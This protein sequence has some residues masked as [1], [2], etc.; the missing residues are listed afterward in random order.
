MKR[1]YQ[2]GAEK[3]GAEKGG[4][5]LR[6]LQLATI[7]GENVERI[8]QGQEGM[9]GGLYDM[10]GH[11]AFGPLDNEPW[12]PPP[13]NWGE[14]LEKKLETVGKEAVLPRL[15]DESLISLREKLN[16]KVD[17]YMLDKTLSPHP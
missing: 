1:H 16:A 4:E 11:R 14:E 5:F 7:K 13:E 12:E 6:M 10:D 3:G 8:Q 9:P 17:L 2:G 15:T